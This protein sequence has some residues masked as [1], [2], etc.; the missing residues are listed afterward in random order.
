MKKILPVFLFLFFSSTLPVFCDDLGLGDYSQGIDNAWYGQKQITDEQFEKTLKAVQDKKNK[1]KNKKKLKGQSLNKYEEGLESSETEDKFKD[2]F[3]N[4][5]VIGLPVNLVTL[6]GV[7]I[8]VGHYNISGKK[9]NK[10]VYLNFYQ[11]D[12]NVASVEATETT[13]DFGQTSINFAKI[14]PCD[15]T[16]IKI[17]YGSVDFNAYAYIPIENGI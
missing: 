6:E 2:V 17:I 9:I 4:N 3:E 15:D 10:K 7:Q 1:K 11:G 12:L 8:P 16:K 14:I 5:A 13:N